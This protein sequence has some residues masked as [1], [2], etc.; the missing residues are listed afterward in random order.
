MCIYAVNACISIVAYVLPNRVLF[1]SVVCPRQLGDHN[2][3]PKEGILVG[4]ICL[5]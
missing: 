5:A 2:I 4:R 3:Q 1:T